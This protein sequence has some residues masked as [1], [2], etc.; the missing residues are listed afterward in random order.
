MYCVKADSFVPATV[1][2]DRGSVPLMFC[3][4]S[5]IDILDLNRCHIHRFPIM[6]CVWVQLWITGIVSI[7]SI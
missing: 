5:A 3:V 4:V 1:V 7:C 6:N 2:S